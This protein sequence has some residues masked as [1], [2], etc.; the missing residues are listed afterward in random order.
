MSENGSIFIILAG[1]SNESASVG[2]LAGLE[3]WADTLKEIELE[4]LLIDLSGADL[5]ARKI[6]IDEG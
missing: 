2:A 5:T 4:A 6:K 3:H 1:F